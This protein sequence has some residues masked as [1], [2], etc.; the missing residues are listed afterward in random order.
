M[1]G[2]FGPF[3]ELSGVTVAFHPHNSLQLAFANTLEAIRLGV[4]IVDG[5]IYGMGRG[6]GNLPTEVLIAYLGLQGRPKY[7]VIP[8]LQ[9]TERYFIEIKK[10]NP[11]GYQLP[12]MISGMLRCNPYYA[13]ELMDRRDYTIE[14]IWKALEVAG[15]MKPI[16]FDRTIIEHLIKKGVV[17]SLGRA[18]LNHGPKPAAEPESRVHVPVP[19]LNRHPGRDCLILAN[20]PSLKSARWT[21][22]PL[23]TAIARS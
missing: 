4:H 17:G 20:G 19:Y 15:E 12:Y 13:T 8:I 3:L 10:E 11:W 2:L 21:F 18:A 7:N 23:S 16:G 14:D 1:A 22:G 6:S 5:S 9:C